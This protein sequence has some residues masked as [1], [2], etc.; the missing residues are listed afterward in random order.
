MPVLD[1]SLACGERL[2]VHQFSV[3]EAVSSLFDVRVLARSPDPCVDLKAI[4][5]Q[6]AALRITSGYNFA[7]EG[8]RLWSGLCHH[9]RLVQAVD[10]GPGEVGLSTYE[11]AIAPLLWLLTQR[12]DYRVFQHLSP[13]DIVRSVL[14]GFRVPASW[15]LYADDHPRLAYKVQVGETDFDFVSRLL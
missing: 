4:V 11:I 15:H 7:R 2:R 10:L 6:P 1:L 3:R 5:G 12:S 8:E 14:E 9:A 13:P